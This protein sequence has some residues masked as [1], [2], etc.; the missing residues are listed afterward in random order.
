LSANGSVARERHPLDGDA[1]LMLP[2]KE[3]A[4]LLGVSVPLL[5]RQH[6]A[7][8]QAYPAERIGTLWLMPTAWVEAKTAWPREVPS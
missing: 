6:L 2:I 8:P 3:V 7:N 4:A 1:R 5:K